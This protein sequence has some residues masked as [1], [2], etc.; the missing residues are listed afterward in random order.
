MI[1]KDNAEH[2]TWGGRCDGWVLVKQDDLRIIHEAMPPGAA[3]VRHY[4]QQARQ[5]F[6]VLE[7]TATLEIAGQPQVLGPQQG[8]EVPPGVAHQM[9]NV[10]AAPV[11]FLVIS[12]P[13]T[14]QDRVP[15]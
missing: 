2:Y 3:E 7:G 15:I 12:Q 8:C 5:F 14:G 1:S 6:F 11:E 10:S 4:H 9:R 13:S